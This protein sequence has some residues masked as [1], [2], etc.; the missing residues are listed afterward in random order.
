M[1]KKN[2]QQWY[3][4]ELKEKLG[5]LGLDASYARA[6]GDFLYQKAGRTETKVL[7]L[8]GGYGANLLGHSHIKLSTAIFDFLKKQ[9]PVF[10][11]GSIWL[12]IRGI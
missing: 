7:D 12:C 3:R 10:V 1:Y 11:Q 6:Q 4:S 5:A 9:T 2:D 8:I